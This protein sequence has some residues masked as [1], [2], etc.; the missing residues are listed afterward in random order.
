M[1]EKLQDYKIITHR[2]LRQAPAVMDKIL[3]IDFDETEAALKNNVKTRRQA[4]K[5][6]KDGGAII[7]FPAGAI[8]LAPK[9]FWCCL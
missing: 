1:A 5:H 7:I 6:L 9:I 8:S 2:A 3:P 4:L